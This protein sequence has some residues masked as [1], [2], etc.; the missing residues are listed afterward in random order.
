MVNVLRFRGKGD[1]SGLIDKAGKRSR[2]FAPVLA[3][4]RNP[5]NGG[6]ARAP[7]SCAACARDCSACEEKAEDVPMA[8]GK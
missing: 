3:A 2:R 7:E 4:P 8:A 5:E 1:L 6:L